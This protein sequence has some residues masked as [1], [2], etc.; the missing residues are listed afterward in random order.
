MLNI[1][2]KNMLQV[3]RK[4]EEA[5][6]GKDGKECK[7]ENLQ[8][9]KRRL[10]HLFHLTD[11]WKTF[12]TFG[13]ETLHVQSWLELGDSLTLSLE[14]MDSYLFL[15]WKKY[16]HDMGDVYMRGTS[17]SEF[18]LQW[19]EAS[20]QV[21]PWNLPFKAYLKWINKDRIHRIF[22][23]FLLNSHWSLIVI[24]SRDHYCLWLDSFCSQPPVSL[25]QPF[26]AE[27]FP[28]I[29]TIYTLTRGD[30]L[31]QKDGV[32]C[33]VFVLLYIEKL[34]QIPYSESFNRFHELSNFKDEDVRTF[35]NKMALTFLSEKSSDVS[36]Q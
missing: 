14:H 2:Y 35:R 11:V 30:F 5:K 3:E 13:N 8:E 1:E 19:N 20:C 9:Y 18:K 29:R 22:I 33:G 26:L 17:F 28:W 36:I 24:Y 15:L 6:D 4:R 31:M 16:S 32:S 23:P 25:L 7:K 10:V 27:Y 34:F 21:Y 12:H